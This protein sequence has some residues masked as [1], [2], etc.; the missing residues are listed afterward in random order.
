MLLDTYPTMIYELIE[1]SVNSIY[2]DTFDRA[3]VLLRHALQLFEQLS[4]GTT[5]KKNDMIAL[6]IF[7]NLALCHQ[8]NGQLLE[9][10]NCLKKCLIIYRK[11]IQPSESLCSQFKHLKYLSK[12]HMQYC[13]ILSQ[14]NKHSEALDHAKYGIKYSHEIL[15]LTAKVAESFASESSTDTAVKKSVDNSFIADC[16]AL[17]T[18]PFCE[19]SDFVEMMAKKSL[20]ILHE[21]QSRFVL[22]TSQGTNKKVLQPHSNN[23]LDAHNLFGYMKCSEWVSGLNI[24]NI[25]QISPLTLQ[26][27]S[28][29]YEEY[30][31]IT[32]ETSLEKIALLSVS[33]FCVSTEKRF[34]AQIS[35]SGPSV[36]KQ[37]EFWH[38]KALEIACCFLPSECPL[39]NHIFSSYQKHHSPLQQA[40]VFILLCFS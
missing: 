22:E 9:C 17:L 4:V 36:G 35:K 37:S 26:D 38:A 2:N 20:P 6:L 27:L 30:M 34:L 29:T 15:S 12:A 14:Q 23:K 16:S 24:G 40:I 5:C 19:A 3:S 31:E 8:K 7:H 10:G 39:V 11:L 18:K 32:R 1:N 28:A 21:L 13:A 33:Y 25:M